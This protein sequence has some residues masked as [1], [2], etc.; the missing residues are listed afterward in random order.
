MEVDWATSATYSGAAATLA[1]RK[2]HSRRDAAKKLVTL[3]QKKYEKLIKTCDGVSSLGRAASKLPIKLSPSSSFS[4]REE[5]A[6]RGRDKSRR[7]TEPPYLSKFT[8]YKNLFQ[9]TNY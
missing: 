6:R 5:A 8:K 4:Q 9:A 3:L 2:D 1:L 7:G